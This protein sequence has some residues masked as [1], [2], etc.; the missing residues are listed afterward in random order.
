MSGCPLYGE[1]DASWLVKD[2]I[3]PA[4]AAAAWR[5][6]HSGMVWKMVEFQSGEDSVRALGLSNLWGLVCC[7]RAGH[8]EHTKLTESGWMDMCSLR[9]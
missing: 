8:F 5:E 2:V 6:F 3:E 1:R 9:I 4:S 7:P